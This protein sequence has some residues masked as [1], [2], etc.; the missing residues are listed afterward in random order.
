MGM[1]VKCRNVRN[2]CKYGS[3]KLNQRINISCG[4][5]R[6][7]QPW[8]IPHSCLRNDRLGKS[9]ENMKRSLRGGKMKSYDD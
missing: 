1:E 9:A 7:N 6:G 3:Q 8:L 4:M 2:F 5:G